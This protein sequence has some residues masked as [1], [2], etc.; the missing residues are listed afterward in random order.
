MTGSRFKHRALTSALVVLLCYVAPVLH[1][2]EIPARLSDEAY[3]LMVNDFSEDGG[4]FRS[5]GGP[6]TK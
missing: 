2:Q 1:A 5:D 6:P 3:W 4:Y